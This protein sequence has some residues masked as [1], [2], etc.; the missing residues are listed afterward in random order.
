MSQQ[1]PSQ[2]LVFGAGDCVAWLDPSIPADLTT[3]V[4]P[5]HVTAILDQA[6]GLT[7]TYGSQANPLSSTSS[8][9]TLDATTLASQALVLKTGYLWAPMVQTLADAQGRFAL[10]YVGSFNAHTTDER[11]TWLLVSQPGAT[12]TNYAPNAFNAGGIL[13]TRV[14][15]TSTMFTL[16]MEDAGGRQVTCAPFQLVNTTFM[17]SL[18]VDVNGNAFPTISVRIN[19]QQIWTYDAGTTNPDGLNFANQHFTSL[20]AGPGADVGLETTGEVIVYQGPLASG[21]LTSIEAYLSPKWVRPVTTITFGSLSQTLGTVAQGYSATI[22]ITNAASV[23]V[24]TVAVNVGSNWLATPPTN[25]TNNWVISGILPPTVTSFLLVLTATDSTGA[26]VVKQAFPI[27]MTLTGTPSNL[28]Q[29]VVPQ[30]PVV[31]IDPSVTG[32]ATV[33]NGRVTYILDRVTAAGLIPTSSETPTLNNTDLART[34]LSFAQPTESASGFNYS[35]ALDPTTRPDVFGNSLTPFLSGTVTP[36]LPMGNGVPITGADGSYTLILVLATTGQPGGQPSADLTI[37]NDFPPT[38]LNYCVAKW[39]IS[40]PTL[41]TTQATVWASDAVT[42]ATVITTGQPATP[43]RFEGNVLLNVGEPALVVWRYDPVNG[44]VLRINGAAVGLNWTHGN[45][46]AWHTPLQCFTQIGGSHSLGTVAEFI[47]FASSLPDA[48]VT[49]IEALLQTKWF[50]TVGVAP[51]IS[52]PTEPSQYAMELYAGSVTISNGG[53]NPITASI[54]ASAGTGWT[55]TQDAT[56][57]TLWHIVGRMPASGNVTVTVT[58][59]QD[60]AVASYSFVLITSPLA[61]APV[62]GTLTPL[63]VGKSAAYSATIV[64]TNAYN[65]NSSPAVSVSAPVGTGWAIAPDSS[66]TPNLYRITGTMPAVLTEFNLTVTA[67]D[68]FNTGFGNNTVT[69]VFPMETTGVA[70]LLT[71]QYPLDLTGLLSTN[72]VTGEQ[73]T[74]TNVNG[75]NGQF[76]VPTLAPFFANG[77]VLQYESLGGLRT[78]QM[79]VDY[80]PVAELQTLSRACAF[81][82][83]TAVAVFN[84]AITGTVTVGYQTLGGNFSIDR[85]ALFTGLADKIIN[86]RELDWSSIVNLPLTYPVAPHTHDV[87]TDLV[88]TSGVAS[89]IESI[90]SAYGSASQ[91]KDLAAMAAHIAR[92]DNPHGVTP[93]QVNLG[94]VPNYPPAT[95]TQAQTASNT[96]TLLTP[97]GAAMAARVGLAQ[98][99]STVAGLMQLNEGTTAGD[100]TDATSGLTAAGLLALM[101]ATG[102]NQIK[103]TFVSGE[104]VALLTPYPI[105]FP[106]FWRGI[107]YANLTA[108]LYAIESYVGV[109]VLPFNQTTGTLFFPKNVT[110]PSLTLSATTT[111]TGTRNATTADDASLPMLVPTG[112]F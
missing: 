3:P 67:N 81:P 25:G 10:F 17:L 55:I 7:Y 32:G 61:T 88:G 106:V 31:W 64:I 2:A 35:L 96:T 44:P 4:T 79:W 93:S 101:T 51:T 83:Y 78:A 33:V 98:A 24:A 91:S 26:Q 63:I 86:A 22:A 76:F 43:N 56:T 16:T 57:A 105:T 15:G 37:Q 13:L 19:G 108:L 85:Q 20:G 34:G 40:T 94:N 74:L 49:P 110:V 8:S 42:D 65:A 62:I 5:D 60:N 102:N 1:T 58:A 107:S 77:M 66:G 71:P 80:A 12:S 29:A 6:L 11:K 68:Q 97:H 54:S 9:P 14:A 69:R 46:G 45:A 112:P 92:T 84:P 28:Q 104:Q 47:A 59:E 30:N 41:G 90:V 18:V 75:A 48:E 38:A 103:T 109:E 72:T 70:T 73:Q 89:S 87:E 111:A 82:L 39:G 21:A 36:N 100:D 95:D 27:E 50:P 99:S 52:N 23:S 53:L